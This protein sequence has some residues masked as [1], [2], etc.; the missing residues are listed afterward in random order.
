MTRVCVLWCV[1]LGTAACSNPVTGPATVPGPEPDSARLTITVVRNITGA[2]IVNAPVS[3]QGVVRSERRTNDEGQ[4]S[5]SV[6]YGERYRVMVCGLSGPE[7]IVAGNDVGWLTSL[8]EQD[9]R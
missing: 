8:P 9:C 6:R 1:L 4:A 7:N 2:P 5:W 3:L